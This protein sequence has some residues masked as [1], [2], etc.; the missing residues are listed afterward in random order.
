MHK[1]DCS[2][3]DFVI[4]GMLLD[5][6]TKARPLNFVFCK[7]VPGLDDCYLHSLIVMCLS[8]ET[9]KLPVLYLML[10][11]SRRRIRRTHELLQFFTFSMLVFLIG[12]VT[13]TWWQY[14]NLHFKDIVSRCMVSWQHESR[15]ARSSENLYC[16]CY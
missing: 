5:Q 12:Y 4:N 16:S 2:K 14:P 9:S 8:R 11:F 7:N 1:V 3:V 15:G 6:C 10:L 13:D